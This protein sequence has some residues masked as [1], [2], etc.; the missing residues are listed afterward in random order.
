M[1]RRNG[2]DDATDDL[3]TGLL[4][5]EEIAAY[6]EVITDAIE[7]APMPDHSGDLVD[8]ADNLPA[9]T[10]SW[11]E[12]QK[13][14]EQ[15]MEGVTV[16]E[17]N[18][19]LLELAQL[20]PETVGRFGPLENEDDVKAMIEVLTAAF[21]IRAWDGGEFVSAAKLDL[22]WPGIYKALLAHRDLATRALMSVG[23]SEMDARIWA[24]VVMMG[25]MDSIVR[26]VQQRMDTAF[27]GLLD[28][29]FLDGVAVFHKLAGSE[30]ILD[31][32][33][34]IDAMEGPPQ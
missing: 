23:Q 21:T 14:G 5:D 19:T 25:Q 27:D 15:I 30:S 9:L 13:A 24:I 32:Q 29:A 22:I 11:A 6:D 31:A 34:I 1:S 26:K 20:C 28:E 2:N 4:S 3:M 18:E 12:F 7:S 17:R 8:E 16:E 33:S 10:L